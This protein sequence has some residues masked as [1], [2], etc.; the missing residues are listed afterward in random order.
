MDEKHTPKRVA[1]HSA[2]DK[3][4]IALIAGGAAAAVL[5]GGYLGLCAWAGSSQNIFPGVCVAGVPV[6]GMSRQDALSLLEENLGQVSSQVTLP[7]E[8]GHWTG[9]ITAAAVQAGVGRHVNGGAGQ[10]PRARS[11]GHAGPGL[12]YSIYTRSGNRASLWLKNAGCRSHQ[13]VC[14]SPK[15]AA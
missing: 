5:L 7:L 13:T 15:R 1:S 11:A 3:K 4:K 6:G 12:N 8:Y 14:Q 9:E 2:P 10:G